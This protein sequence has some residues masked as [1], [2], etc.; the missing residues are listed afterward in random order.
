MMKTKALITEGYTSLLKDDIDIVFHGNNEHFDTIIGSIMEDDDENKVTKHVH[1]IVTLTVLSDFTSG[2]ISYLD[3]LKKASSI[4][5][6]ET[7]YSG[8]QTVT[9]S[10]FEDFPKDYLPSEDSY[11]TN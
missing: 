2:K 1:S 3:V 6:V 9:E 5:L 4:Y 11:L 10:K 7:K 8:E